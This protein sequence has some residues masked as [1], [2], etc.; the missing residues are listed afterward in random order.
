MASANVANVMT[1]LGATLEAI[2]GL[3]VYDYPSDQVNPPAA[4]VAFPELIEFD[5]TMSRGSDR[6]VV[7]VHVLV[8]RVSERTAVTRLGDYLSGSGIKAA[9]EADPT[10][11]GSV[12]TT[13]VTD[14]EINVMT[15]GGI[16]FLAAT[17]TVEILT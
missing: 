10:L 12:Q 15:V 16:D 9:V 17:F 8:G 6:L 1:R 4:V 3:R 5:S 11:E 13:R 7:P 14:A 2:T